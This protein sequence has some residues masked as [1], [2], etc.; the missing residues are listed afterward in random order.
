[1]TVKFTNN[2]SST[3]SS[4]INSSVTSLTVASASAFPQLAGADDYC[5]LTIQQATGTVREVVKATALSSNT[6]TI[7]RAQDNTT[8]QSFS[9]GDT[10]ELRM[11][12]ALLTDVIDAATVEGVKTN[13]QYT[14]T[15]GQTVFSGADNSS[16]TM[17]INQSGLV[18]VYMNGVRLVQGTDYTVSAANNTITLTTGATTADIIDIEV[19]GNFTGQSG[20][21]VAITGGSITGTAITATTLGASGTATLNT[22]VSSNATLSGGTINNVAI[23]GTTQAAGNFTDI[24]GSTATLTTA[25]N[26]AQLTLKSTD[27]DSAIGPRLDLTRD[28]SSPSDGDAVG[29][30]RFLADNDAGQELSFGFIRMFLSDVSDGA[31]GGRL[32]I[33]TRVNGTNRN[34]LKC[35]SEETVFNEDSI[36]LDFRVE[37]NNKQGMFIVDG[38][39]DVVK[40][41]GITGSADG[42]LKVKSNSNH[43][44]LA[45]EENSGNEAYSLGVVADGSLIFANSGT[46]VVR[47]DD[48]GQVGIGTDN[49]SELLEVHGDTPV[50]KLRDTSAHSAGTGPSINFQGQDSGSTIRAFAAISGVSTSG[51]NEGELTFST[52][53]SGNLSERI[54]VDHDGNFLVSTT[55]NS[56]VGNNVAGIGL[57]ANGSAQ[58]S[59][60]GGAPLF[61]NRKTSNGDLIIL[62]KDGSTVGT[63]GVTDGDLYVAS[64]ASGHKGLRF[65]N[66][67]IAP[68]N[69]AGTI[70]DNSTDLGYPS[71]RFKDLYLGGNLLVGKTSLSTNSVGVEAREDGTFAAVKSGGGAAVFGRTTDDG[72]IVTFR[73]NTTAVGSIG[74]NGTALFIASPH[75]ND[76]G[77]KFGDRKIVPCTTAGVGRDDAIDLGS[78]ST[79]FDTIFAKS[80]TINTS[81]LNEKQDIEL[82]SDAEMRVAKAA[83]GLLRKYRWKSSVAEKG[84]DARIHFGIVA[85]DLQAAFEAEGLDAARYGMWCSD[86]WTDEETGEEHTRLGVR[87][88]ELLAF[89]IA[90]I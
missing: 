20:A 67:Y 84:D 4:G 45:L 88:S 22:F 89:I 1:M 68:T 21:A 75:G 19:Y 56:P 18:N 82:L 43:L 41:G 34:R 52:R 3:L 32:E 13:F 59:R 73:K 30:I 8:A 29:Q 11:T 17:I 85:Q 38:G 39:D 66:G 81:D 9:A 79:R 53:K 5:Y 27:P 50:F 76:S 90:V 61:V 55:N 31:E 74:N 40:I 51:T 78:S 6:F 44:A 60:D 15:A 46:E 77:V 65:G 10:V 62:R 28:S 12:A 64:S 35:T 83:K 7:I 86:T 49:P 24:T 23:G 69:N 2:A 14:P 26:N 47:F 57:M 36:D 70:Q 42:T 72:T 37:S 25:G 33:D 63:Q 16:N 58:L 71:H 87:Y 48:S 54:R 80:S